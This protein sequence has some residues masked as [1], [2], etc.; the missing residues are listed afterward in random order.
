[1]RQSEQINELAAALAKA[2]GQ[3]TN[4]ARNREVEVKPRESAAYS[5]KYATFDAI[6]DVVR[7][8][9]S[10]NGLALVQGVA[11]TEQGLVLTTKLLHA[12]GQWLESDTPIFYTG[13]KAQAF[14][15]GVS[16]AKRYAVASLLGVTADEDDDGNAAEG[17]AA[18]FKDR[19]MPPKPAARP[20]NVERDRHFGNAADEIRSGQNGIPGN[21][22]AAN[23]APDPK[24]WAVSDAAGEFLRAAKSDLGIVATGDDMRRWMEEFRWE[25]DAILEYGHGKKNARGLTRADFLNELVAETQ[26]RCRTN[27]LPVDG[28]RGA[29]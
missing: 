20:P 19:K 14:G 12:T 2:Q 18:K 17:N 9:L 5:F 29:A 23:A 21:K 6:L 28:L 24:A 1:M 22:P 16:Y 27:A 26:D 10:D 25:H 3:F 15:S 4:P 13:D 8:P 7:K 11:T